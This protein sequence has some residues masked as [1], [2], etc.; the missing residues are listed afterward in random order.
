VAP[1]TIATTIPFSLAKNARQDVTTP[2]PCKDTKGGWV[3]SGTIRNS[4]TT[5]RTYQIVVDFVT[6][7]GNT[8]L[9]TKVIT[10][11]PVRPGAV[12]PWSA[13]STPGLHHLACV[14]RQVQAP[15]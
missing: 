4:A 14:I 10:T 2:S 8:V 1:A 5:A 7:T 6:T 15:A 3:L 9:D 12:L 13:T 11:P